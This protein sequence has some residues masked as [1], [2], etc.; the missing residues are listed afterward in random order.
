MLFA[1]YNAIPVMTDKG[2]ILKFEFV[3]EPT[4]CGAARSHRSGRFTAQA[5][6]GRDE[7]AAA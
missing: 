5:K 3:N 4:A 7:L 1:Q 2:H 6:E